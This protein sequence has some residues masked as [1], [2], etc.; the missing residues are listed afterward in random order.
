[1]EKYYSYADWTLVIKNALFSI[2]SSIL[3]HYVVVATCHHRGH[4]NRFL[5][6]WWFS[7]FGGWGW[8]RHGS[9]ECARNVS[10]FYFNSLKWPKFHVKRDTV[11]FTVSK[12]SGKNSN[13]SHF[14]VQIMILWWKFWL[15]MTLVW[16]WSDMTEKLLYIKPLRRVTLIKLYREKGFSSLSSICSDHD[17][18]VETLIYR[19]ADVNSTD[20]SGKTPL[21]KAASEGNSKKDCIKNSD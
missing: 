1:M 11:F 10:K 4:H 15:I 12:I 17:D 13:L 21:H 18:T 8:I 19:G 20:Y 14:F 5:E 7:I 3:N 2:N 16:I 9:L 6:N